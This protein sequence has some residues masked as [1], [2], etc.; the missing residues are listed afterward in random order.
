MLT[1]K[2]KIYLQSLANPLKT[3]VQV[4]KEGLTE[5]V[6]KEIKSALKSHE[7]I[8]I[9]LSEKNTKK[10]KERGKRLAEDLDAEFIQAIGF[11]IILYKRNPKKNK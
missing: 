11:K 3:V 10:T 5:N 7:L 2:Q 4:G 6:L 8:K 1:G 9:A